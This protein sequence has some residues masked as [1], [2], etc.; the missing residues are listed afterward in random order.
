MLGSPVGVKF[1][2]LGPATARY[3]HFSAADVSPVSALPDV[4]K[5]AA[6][7]LALCASSLFLSQLICG[8]KQN[9]IKVLTREP[10]L[11][12]EI[13]KRHNQAGQMKNGK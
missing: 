2:L 8:G 10:E 5:K 11:C 1:A 12:S 3:S 7:Q 9:S 4:L 6:E 13:R